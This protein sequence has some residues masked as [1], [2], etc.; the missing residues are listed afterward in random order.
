MTQIWFVSLV[1]VTLGQH[2]YRKPRPFTVSELF[3]WE[4]AL[5]RI[6]AAH[7]AC[8]LLAQKGYLE[9]CPA[10]ETNPGANKNPTRPARWQMTDIGRE[11]A[12]ASQLAAASRKRSSTLTALNESRTYPQ[13]LTERLW[14]VLRARRVITVPEAVDVLGDA[15]TDVRSLRTYISNLLAMW[16]TLMPNTIQLSAHKVGRCKRYVLVGNVGRLPPPQLRNAPKRAAEAKRAV[17]APQGASA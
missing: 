3:A 12:R 1:L 11:A 8:S 16:H 14:T 4:P 13:A 9:P 7:R 10:P 15:G 5:G 17:P 6:S 2:L